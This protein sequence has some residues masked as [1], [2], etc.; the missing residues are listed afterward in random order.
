MEDEGHC[1]LTCKEFLNH[2]LGLTLSIPGL[3]SFAS[4]LSCLYVLYLLCVYLVG[5]HDPLRGEPGL[6]DSWARQTAHWAVCLWLLLPAGIV[7]CLHIKQIPDFLWEVE[8]FS[9]SQPSPLPPLSGGRGKQVES[10]K[11]T[12][13]LWRSLEFP[14]SID[15]GWQWHRLLAWCALCTL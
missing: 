2:T 12:H 3:V 14:W 6:L 11:T 15:I 4:L 13:P 5:W 1:L 7:I 8:F 9:F 10:Q